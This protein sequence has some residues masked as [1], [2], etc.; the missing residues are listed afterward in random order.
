MTLLQAIAFCIQISMAV[1][2]FCVALNANR[3]DLVHAR[4]PGFLLRSVL[5]MNVI[6]PLFVIGLALLFDLKPGV[7]IALL[8][9][10]L[11]PV[12]P[13][14]PNRQ[15]KAGGAYSSIIGVLVATALFSV[16]LVPAA[17]WTLNRIFG[18]FID[19]SAGSVAVIVCTSVLLPIAA[20]A[21]FRTIAPFA[22]KRITQPLATGAA[23]LLALSFIPVLALEWRAMIALIG[24]FT[25]LAIVAFVLAG[26]AAGHLLGGPD[27]DDRSVLALAAASRHPA[28]AIM[29]LRDSPE[30]DA[31]LAAILLTLVVGLIVS[32]P[33]VKRRG[34]DHEHLVG[35]NT[36]KGKTGR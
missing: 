23:C 20:G 8:A 2:V 17:A 7:E 31:A 29:L 26:L 27:P 30:R 34:R 22:A 21:V 35:L 24:N 14:L 32:G 1:I 10:A 11:S 16:L 25:L 12:P 6:M 4:R 9:L 5:A 18:S 19:A 33:Y 13:F 15:L 28:I 3:E 36:A